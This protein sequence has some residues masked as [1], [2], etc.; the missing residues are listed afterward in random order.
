[1]VG[2]EVRGSVITETGREEIFHVVVIVHTAEVAAHL[3]VGL[4][5]G[6][7]GGLGRNTVQGLDIV[8]CSSVARSVETIPA[9]VYVVASEHEIEVVFLS[10][11]LV[12]VEHQVILV[13]QIHVVSLVNRAVFYHLVVT[14]K[15]VILAFVIGEREHRLEM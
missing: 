5:R 1:M 10:E 4:L 13:M 11:G 6:C 3:L 8:G 2:G 15:I 14:L 12:I 7:L 9:V